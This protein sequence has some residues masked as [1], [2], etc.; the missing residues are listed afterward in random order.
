LSR[1][2]PHSYSGSA[3]VVPPARRQP[4]RCQ[5]HAVPVFIQ[6]CFATLRSKVPSGAG[7]VHELKFD[8]YRAQAHLREGRVSLYTRSGLDWT[9]RFPTIAADCSRGWRGK[10]HTPGC[11]SYRVTQIDS[12][13]GDQWFCTKAEAKAA[14]FRKASNCKRNRT[15]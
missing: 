4:P 13:R 12:K 3:F 9:N 8:G 7:Y 1:H 6:P 15:R 5:G 2:V 14:S 11:A 10:Y